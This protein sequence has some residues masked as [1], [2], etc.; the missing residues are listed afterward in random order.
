MYIHSKRYFLFGN[1]RPVFFSLFLQVLRFVERPSAGD[2]TSL[3]VDGSGAY[4]VLPGLVPVSAEF[5][6]TANAAFA[7][8]WV[9][10]VVNRVS[11]LATLED[12]LGFTPKVKR[13]HAKPSEAVHSFMF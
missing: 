5:D 10:N 4:R 11:F 1:F 8:H 6:G 13:K 9:S 7:D 12:T 2:I 3:A